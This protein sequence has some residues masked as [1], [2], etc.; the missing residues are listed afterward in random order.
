MNEARANYISEVWQ[1]TLK[2]HE[3][4]IATLQEQY[5]ADTGIIIEKKGRRIWHDETRQY[6][7]LELKNSGVIS[8]LSYDAEFFKYL[9]GP[10]ISYFVHRDN[11][12]VM[13]QHGIKW[14]RDYLSRFAYSYY[15]RTTDEIKPPRNTKSVIDHVNND[16]YN[17]CRWNLARITR[18]QNGKGAKWNLAELIKPPYFLYPIIDDDGHYRILFGWNNGGLD[19]LVAE[20]NKTLYPFMC[21]NPDQFN[22]FLKATVNMKDS[23]LCPRRSPAEALEETVAKWFYPA[24]PF[25]NSARYAERLLATPQDAFI[26]WTAWTTWEKILKEYPAE[27]MTFQR[28][29]RTYFVPNLTYDDSVP[30]V[31]VKEAKRE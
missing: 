4:Y 11:G 5:P 12:R 2:I 25:G 27:R 1:D 19:D 17:N 30:K 22:A 23:L 28:D 9:A 29:P 8:T 21:T 3:P 15:H 7:F 14:H 6:I 18:E 13:I 10:G 16:I 24:L 20:R 31:T 26:R